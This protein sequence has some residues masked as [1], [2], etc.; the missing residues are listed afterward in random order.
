LLDWGPLGEGLEKLDREEAARRCETVFARWLALI[1][2]IVGS[3][4]VGH[5]P[6]PFGPTEAKIVDGVLRSLTGFAD[7]ATRLRTITVGKLWAALDNPSDEL[8][9]A[10]RYQSR[11]QFWNETRLLR[12]SISTL[13]KGPLQGLFDQ[14]TSIDLDWE[15]PIASLSLS[16]LDALGDDA[17][18]IA[19]LILSSWT[20]G[21]REQADD[22]RIVVRDEIWRIMRLGLDA[23]K[24]FDA[25][26]RLSRKDG[27]I[28][29]TVAHKPSDFPSVGDAGSQAAQIAKDMVHLADTKVLFGQDQ[30]VGEELAELLGLSEKALGLVTRWAKMDKG[31][32]LWLVGDECHK[33]QHVL[34]PLELN[35]TYTQDALEAAK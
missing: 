10:S 15:A 29:V 32:A 18:S 21:M 25:D 2:G 31:R 35:L 9:S 17:V 23:V 14:E 8:V 27:E 13:L 1:G 26:L 33:V 11:Q 34:H 7:G 19:L 30:K 3:Q 16:R 6:V 22:M 24:S 4:S 28:P 12:D 20:R 5:R